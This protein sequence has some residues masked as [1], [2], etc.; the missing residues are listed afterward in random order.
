MG[1][2]TIYRRRDYFDNGF[3][4]KI[5]GKLV[6]NS[7]ENNEYFTVNVPAGELRI[8]TYGSYFT[9]KTQFLLTVKSGEHYF[10]KGTTDYDYFSSKFHLRKTDPANGKREVEKLKPDADAKVD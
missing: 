8:E 2:L 3:S 10:L 9:L 1:Q 6:T 7:L 5:N 4:V